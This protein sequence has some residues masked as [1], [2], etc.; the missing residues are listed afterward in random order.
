ML[1]YLL[2]IVVS[3]SGK[4]VVEVEVKGGGWCVRVLE[5][6]TSQGPRASLVPRECGGPALLSSCCSHSVSSCNT[7]QPLPLPRPVRFLHSARPSRIHLLLYLEHP[8]LFF[9][10]GRPSSPRLLLL[11][12]SFLLSLLLILLLPLCPSSR[13]SFTSFGTSFSFFPLWSSFQPLFTSL[14]VLCYPLSF[15]ILHLLATVRPSNIHLLLLLVRSCLFFRPGRPP[16]LALIHYFWCSLI[17]FSLLILPLLLHCLSSNTLL[18]LLLGRPCLFFRS[19]RHPSPH[20]LL[21]M[22]SNLFSFPHPSS[23]P[24]LSV[25]P[26][27]INFFLWDFLVS[28]SSLVV[29]LS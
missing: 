18:F 10:S 3:F 24:T 25:L 22:F 1:F 29:L 19:D 7:L 6:S 12:F 4:V 23:S 20:S 9:L 26:T 5:S 27:L 13:H 28:S 2:F 14:G 8:F 17:S 15:F 16:L 11:A 21:F